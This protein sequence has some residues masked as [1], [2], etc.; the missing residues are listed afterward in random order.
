MVTAIISCNNSNYA[1]SERCT[2][3]PQTLKIEADG[4]YSGKLVN[5]IPYTQK[6]VLEAN[7]KL[8]RFQLE[9]AFWFISDKG[10]FWADD[11][12]QALSIYLAL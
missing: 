12:L 5:G 1:L 6:Q 10:V 7:F 2:A 4:S 3:P 8:H 9:D 11:N